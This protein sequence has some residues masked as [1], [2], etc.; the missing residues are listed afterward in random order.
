MVEIRKYMLEKRKNLQVENIFGENWKKNF[1]NEA[2]KYFEFID[3]QTKK[4]YKYIIKIHIYYMSKILEKI[5][6]SIDIPKSTYEEIMKLLSYKNKILIILRTYKFMV[7]LEIKIKRFQDGDEELFLF[8]SA[9]EKTF[10]KIAEHSKYF[11]QL[12][13]YAMNYKIYENEARPRDT[14]ES[15][16]RKYLNYE[17][18]N[19]IENDNKNNINI[20][21]NENDTMLNIENETSKNLIGN[22]DDSLIKKKEIKK[23]DN[24]LLKDIAF[25]SAKIFEIENSKPEGLNFDDYL[26]FPP[27]FPFSSNY[28]KR[29]KNYD[30]SDQFF[31]DDKTND[32]TIEYFQTTAN[33]A[34]LGNNG[35]TKKFTIKKNNKSIKKSIDSTS[36]FR[37]I[38]KVRLLFI[39]FDQ[40]FKL[41]KIY[42]DEIAEKDFFKRSQLVK[43]YQNHKLGLLCDSMNIFSGKTI[44][45]QIYHIRNLFGE[46]V[47]FYILWIQKLIYF[48]MFPA[49]LGLI[50]H[51]L[52]SYFQT[53]DT[54]KKNHLF[55]FFILQ[56]RSVDIVR[57]L[58]CIFPPICV[59]LFLKYWD[60]IEKIYS[61]FW[62][63]EK[64]LENEPYQESY[65]Y[66]KETEF[67]FDLK[68]K[69]Q[70]KI[71]YYLRCT[72]SNLISLLMAL[73]VIFI[74]IQVLSLKQK[75]KDSGNYFW[76]YFPSVLNAVSIKILSILYR[77]IANKLSI[78]ENHE[79]NSE[80]IANLSLKIFM[81]EFVNNFFAYYYI[82]FYKFNSDTLKC[83]DNDCMNEIS[84]QCYLSLIITFSLNFLEIGLP[85]IIN[86][87]LL[88]D[89]VEKRKTNQRLNEN[90][91]NNLHSEMENSYEYLSKVEEIDDLIE[92]Y[93]EI[94]ILIAYVLL[95]SSSAPLTPLLVM[96]LLLIE[97]GIDV[98]K[99]YF[100]YRLKELR[101]FSTIT[102]FNYM[103]IFLLFF[104]SFTNI[105]M[106]VFSRKFNYTDPKY[107]NGEDHGHVDLLVKIFLLMIIQ[108]FV[109]FTNMMLRFN[110]LPNCKI[111]FF[112][113]LIIFNLF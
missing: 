3:Y 83:I 7:D 52:V 110:L 2:F 104:G 4:F 13:P 36:I 38:D 62:G 22:E 113:F 96:I 41:N 64:A 73:L 94:I 75:N 12:K 9:N 56:V 18:D 89:L 61:Y 101:N 37:S 5:V 32:L 95:L 57:G 55:N 102:V 97:K 30:N 77:Y 40:F 47:A 17:N 19:D 14:E 112:I 28:S 26:N 106:F 51:I 79:K 69:E 105:S 50:C 45:N 53:I 23:S 86:S 80:R 42:I 111:K 108:N 39:S 100:L 84:V 1:Y 68:L 85:M 91:E 88:N 8:F 44:K 59:S 63:I 33:I 15:N 87:L 107:D 98:H 99:F 34:I 49:F 66:Q 35:L 72:V 11:L 76:M 20:N 93:L 82:A 78:W 48:M 10:I 58:L 60:D 65:K 6:Q 92:E 16:L 46:E 90:E 29:F 81:F 103:I 25:K 70:S 71:Y 21:E 54:N 43:S 109:L 67:I 31:V 24:K 74:N 27:Y